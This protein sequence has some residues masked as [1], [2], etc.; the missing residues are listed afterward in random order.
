MKIYNI[1][2]GNRIAI[3]EPGQAGRLA[4]AAQV[5]PFYI[6]KGKGWVRLA[7]TTIEAAKEEAQAGPVASNPTAPSGRTVIAAVAEYL[8]EVRGKNSDQTYKNY[9]SRLEGRF[10]TDLQENS[11]VRD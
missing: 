9:R 3:W 6:R 7:A 11:S 2:N 5:A 4:E 8:E 10:L 1:Q